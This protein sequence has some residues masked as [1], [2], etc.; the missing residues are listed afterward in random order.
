MPTNQPGIVS[1][2]QRSGWRVPRRRGQPPAPP[3]WRR[4]SP[5]SDQ[6]ARADERDNQRASSSGAVTPQDT[7]ADVPAEGRQYQRTGPLESERCASRRDARKYPRRPRAGFVG[8][9]VHHGRDEQGHRR[10]HR[11]PHSH[12]AAP[13][14]ASPTAD[15]DRDDQLARLSGPRWLI[16]HV[17]GPLPRERRRRALRNRLTAHGGQL[18]RKL[19]KGREERSSGLRLWPV[20]GAGGPGGMAGGGTC[21]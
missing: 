13:R 17:G 16:E 19:P 12:R 8:K 14:P 7:P 6:T 21:G 1:R 15:V 11:S 9:P 18:W 20:G 5:M 2:R 3:H 10:C 4:R